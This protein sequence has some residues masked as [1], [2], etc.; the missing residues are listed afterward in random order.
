VL[1]RQVLNELSK[2]IL[3][4]EISKDAVVEATLEDGK[5]RFNNIDL[6]L[7]LTDAA[8]DADRLSGR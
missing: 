4:G 1:Q 5:I 3:S 2:S 7:P 6:E 8:S